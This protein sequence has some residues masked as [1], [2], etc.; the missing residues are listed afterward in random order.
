MA[1]VCRLPSAA[2]YEK[3]I[4]RQI[5]RQTKESHPM[6]QATILPKI[7]IKDCGGSPEK[8]LQFDEGSKERWPLLRVYGIASRTR[9]KKLTNPNTGEVSIYEAITGDFR[10]VNLQTGE[11]FQGGV[12]Y[13]P[14]GIHDLIAEPLRS[15]KENNETAEVTFAMDLFSERR[16]NLSKYGYGATV[17]GEPTVPDHIA[18]LETAIAKTPGVAQIADQ[19][20]KSK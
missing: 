8:V 5:R 2:D 15:A 10:A 6:A 19:T 11:R 14:D 18:A 1:F 3:N 16:N 9:E 20:S 7:T 4:T 17:L 13:L 12:L